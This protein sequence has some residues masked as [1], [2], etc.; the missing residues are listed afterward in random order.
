MTVK[1]A[2]TVPVTAQSARPQAERAAA[3]VVQAH[4][5]P[6]PPVDLE[7]VAQQ[8]ESFLKRVNRSIE[9]RVDDTSGRVV[10]S[11]RDAETGDLIRQIPNEEVLRLA[12]LAHDETIVL[13]NEKA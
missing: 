12:E 9:F 4:A 8:M 11:V 2:V 6:P 10:C 13:V 3:P 7:K 5:P 1:P